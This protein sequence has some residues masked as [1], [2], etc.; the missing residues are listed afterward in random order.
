MRDRI[1]SHARAAA[2][3]ECCGVILGDGEALRE[4]VS[5]TNLDPGTD[6]YRI[7][8]AE[9]FRVYRHADE[10]GWDFR[11][12]YH[13]HPVSRAYP[14]RTD[15]SLAAWPDAV[16]VICSLALPDAPELHAFR[17]VD[18]AIAEIPIEDV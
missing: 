2:P 14:S 4:L 16:Y 7:D 13:S 6:F 9:L 12:I 1:V 3:R 8:D 18:E 10:R 15:V 17:I 5:L 11:V